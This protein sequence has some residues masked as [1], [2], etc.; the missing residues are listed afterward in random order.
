MSK[1]QAHRVASFD[2]LKPGKVN[3]EVEM[4]DGE[5]LLFPMRLPTYFDILDM[6]GRIPL[7]EAPITGAD[8]NG[9]PLRNYS[10]PGYIANANRVVARRNVALLVQSL[11]MDIPGDTLEEKTAA[12]ETGISAR[13]MRQLMAVLEGVMRSGEARVESRVT[14][15]HEDGTGDAADNDAPGDNL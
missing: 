4:E 5:I 12:L 14:T 13:V 2:D 6:E 1:E 3:I 11:D 10:D 9:R 7:P 8:R 15:F